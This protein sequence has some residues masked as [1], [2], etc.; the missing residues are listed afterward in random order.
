MYTAQ[1]QGATKERS[2][3]TMLPR[4]VGKHSFG[5]DTDSDRTG[6]GERRPLGGRTPV[7][8]KVMIFHKFLKILRQKLVKV[9]HN[10][11]VETLHDRAICSKYLTMSEI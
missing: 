6:H 9:Q 7:N 5:R 1:D 3:T 8:L 11:L 2:Q 4:P 10:R